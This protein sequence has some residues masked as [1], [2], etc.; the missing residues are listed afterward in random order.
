MGKADKSC[1]FNTFLYCK[2]LVQWPI[3][4][5]FTAFDFKRIYRLFVILILL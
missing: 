5:K 4:G 3:Y 2:Y 1:I